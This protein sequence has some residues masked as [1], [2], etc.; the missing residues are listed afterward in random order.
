M[1]NTNTPEFTIDLFET[2]SEFGLKTEPEIDVISQEKI[3]DSANFSVL[4]KIDGKVFESSYF[5]PSGNEVV[6]KRHKKR[7]L[8]LALYNA[9]NTLYPTRLPWGSL[10]G[11]RPTKLCYQI[12]EEGGNFKEEFLNKFKVS[13]EKTQLVSKILQAQKKYYEKTENN[14]GLFVSIP[15]CPS[16]C[17]YCSFLSC[18]IGKVKQIDDYVSALCKEIEASKPLIKNLRSVYVG[19]GTP[20]SLKNEHFERILSAIGKTNVEYTIEAGRPDCITEENLKIMKKYGVSRVCV[21]PQTLC[22]ETLKILGRKHTSKDIFEK[23]ELVRSFGF[24]INMDLICGLP[25][26]NFDTFK[27]TLDRVCQLNP[28]NITIHTLALKR[29]SKL[30]QTTERLSGEIVEK[31]VDYGHKK[32]EDE[33]YQPYYLYRQK[34]MAGNLENTGYA[35]KGKEC[36]YNVDMMEEIAQ[37]IGCGANSVS[38]RIFIDENRLERYG[39]PKDVVTYINKIEKI[40]EEKSKLFN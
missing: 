14:F 5:I 17:A 15:F 23:F 18:E 16:R 39:A 26:E 32:L 37:I 19:G 21:N 22:D 4:I 38:K 12:M 20:V 30:K 36:V 10:T 11:I 9:I 33:G 24:D 27:S 40:I 1:L 25:G 34:Y 31:M 13:S 35:K 3:D 28:E 29:G 8:K 2:I 6:V 7:F